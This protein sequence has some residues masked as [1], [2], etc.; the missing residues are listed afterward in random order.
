MRLWVEGKEREYREVGELIEIPA[1]IAR[2][3]FLARD[4]KSRLM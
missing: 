3:W 1:I 2:I 4:T